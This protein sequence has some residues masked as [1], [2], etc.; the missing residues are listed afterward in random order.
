MTRNDAPIVEAVYATNWSLTK[1]RPRQV[2]PTPDAPR[3]TSFASCLDDMWRRG[4]GVRP[5]VACCGLSRRGCSEKFAPGG[6]GVTQR[7]LVLCWSSNAGNVWTCGCKLTK[8]ARVS[9]IL[10]QLACAVRSR[11]VRERRAPHQPR[12]AHRVRPP[13]LLAALCARRGHPAGPQR[14]VACGGARRAARAGPALA[15]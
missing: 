10:R 5:C 1:R 11:V 12:H 13:V 7:G 14:V 8:T 2:L 15:T 6:N 9:S 4:G 3:M